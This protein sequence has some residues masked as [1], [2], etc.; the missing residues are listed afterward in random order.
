MTH[1]LRA[2][3]LALAL[4]APVAA[5]AI[6]AAPA[7]DPVTGAA[8]DAA[9]KAAPA[10]DA[11]ARPPL[12]LNETQQYCQNIAAAAADARFAWQ[13]KRISDLEAQLKQ[14]IADLEAREAAFKEFLAHRDEVMK[15]ATDT[16]VGIYSHMK[17]DVAA[18][19]LS[20]LDDDLAAAIL[21]HL[22]QKQASIILNEVDP[23]RAVKLINTMT[24]AMPTEKK[25]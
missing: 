7:T 8:P 18:K 20:G 15:R 16:V 12:Q 5:F 21:T 6:E 22:T 10:R 11:A 3:L 13:R 9:P 17:P 14:R 1:A 25:S 19:Q 23:D 24:A 2:C 4:L